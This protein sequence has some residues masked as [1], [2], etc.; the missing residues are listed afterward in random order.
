MNESAINNQN[1]ANFAGHKLRSKPCH[2]R[3][4]FCS[5]ISNEISIPLPRFVACRSCTRRWNT[6]FHHE[7][8][9]LRCTPIFLVKICRK[10]G[11]KNGEAKG[12]REKYGWRKK[13]EFE[14][15]VMLYRQCKTF[16]TLLK[17]WNIR[18]HRSAKKKVSSLGCCCRGGK[19]KSEKEEKLH[20]FLA[21]GKYWKMNTVGVTPNRQSAA[22]SICFH[23]GLPVFRSTSTRH[24]H[25][26]VTPQLTHSEAKI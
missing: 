25:Q 8:L 7:T 9:Q 13:I 26:T 6:F 20:Y 22:V 23:M 17:N 5:L 15:K 10:L 16:L 2:F 14:K 19:K 11:E 21:T 3:H 12:N 1:A 4:L 18:S 24:H